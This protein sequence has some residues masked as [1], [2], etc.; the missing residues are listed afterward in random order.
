MMLY[1]SPPNSS[2]SRSRLGMHETKRFRVQ[3]SA[4]ITVERATHDEENFHIFFVLR[5]RA[6]LLLLSHFLASS[7]PFHAAVPL[8]CSA[9]CCV[10]LTVESIFPNSQGKSAET[11]AQHHIQ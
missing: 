6:A 3:H 1:V 11:E 10:L 7:F 4:E 2:S 5:V 9:L 8:S